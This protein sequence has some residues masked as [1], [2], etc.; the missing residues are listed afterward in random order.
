MEF[1]IIGFAKVPEKIFDFTWSYSSKLP[2]ITSAVVL[3]ADN[4]LLMAIPPP[5][6]NTGLDHAVLDQ[7]IC[8]QFA[9]RIDPDSNVIAVNDVTNEVYIS[10]K[11]KLLK[12]YKLP[13]DYLDKLD[14]KIKAAPIPI[15]EVFGHPLVTR[16]MVVSKDGR[17]LFTGGKDGTVF[18]RE[19][20]NITKFTE[21][22]AH[23]LSA[24]GVSLI[25]VSKYLPV[26]YTGSD[27][28]SVIMWAYEDFDF[29]EVNYGQ[30]KQPTEAFL[31]VEILEDHNDEDL[32]HYKKVLE[33]EYNN[34]NADARADVQAQFKSELEGIKRK[35]NEILITNQYA[36]DLEK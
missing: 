36:D 5:P 20:I 29:E 11:D 1:N 8:P 9:R 35:L 12:K 21:I 27:D 31:N 34:R 19:A 15:E 24:N 26:I 18:A 13:E 17:I 25:T 2:K 32:M 33:D 7:E 14:K 10:G 4:A 22:K 16:T 3:V 28:G 23:S 6:L 30:P